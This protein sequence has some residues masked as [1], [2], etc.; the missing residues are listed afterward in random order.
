MS[1][2]QNDARSGRCDRHPDPESKPICPIGLRYPTNALRAEFGKLLA[3][4]TEN[5]GQGRQLRRNQE[6]TRAPATATLQYV[7]AVPQ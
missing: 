7:A 4:E 1:S 3:D 5:G 6:G 2:V